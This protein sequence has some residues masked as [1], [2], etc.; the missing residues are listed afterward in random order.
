MGKIILLLI[1][2]PIIIIF[3]IIFSLVIGSL[4][5]HINEG[6]NFKSPLDSQKPIDSIFRDKEFY[7]TFF[8]GLFPLITLIIIINYLRG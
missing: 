8:T 6:D 4:I 2:V 5:R 3:T 7:K 1:V